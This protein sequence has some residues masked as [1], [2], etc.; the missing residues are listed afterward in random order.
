[1]SNGAAALFMT[2]VYPRTAIYFGDTPLVLYNHDAAVLSLS[3]DV[4]AEVSDWDLG[5]GHGKSHPQS[6]SENVDVLS[7]PRSEVAGLGGPDGSRVGY[8]HQP[9]EVLVVQAHVGSVTHVGSR[10]STTARDPSS[11]GRAG[12][13][14]SCPPQSAWNCVARR[15]AIGT[16]INH[17][18]RRDSQTSPQVDDT[19]HVP[20]ASGGRHSA[21][22]VHRPQ[23]GTRQA[24]HLGRG[25][26]VRPWDPRAGRRARGLTSTDK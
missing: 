24:G 17:E 25:V 5:G 21:P 9:T 16:L 14:P 19:Q 15:S 22:S 8:V 4:E 3:A 7:E 10:R 23:R 11:W 18:N 6:I 2:T 1:M 26:A 12:R 13:L 20:D